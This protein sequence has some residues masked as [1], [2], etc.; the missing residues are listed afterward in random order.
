[1]CDRLKCLQLV[2]TVISINAK[3]AQLNDD[4]NQKPS[5]NI[6]Y[7]FCWDTADQAC[8]SIALTEPQHS[9]KRSPIYRQQLVKPVQLEQGSRIICMYTSVGQPMAIN[10]V[11]ISALPNPN[12][13]TM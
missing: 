7:I 1:M 3:Q 4:R 13:H 6:T 11:P 2:K 10:L 12:D 8:C 9:E 5:C